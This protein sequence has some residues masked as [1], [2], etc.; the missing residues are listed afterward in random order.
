MSDAASTPAPTTEPSRAGRLLDLVR[1]LI[2]YGKELAATIRQRAVTDP[3]F[4]K[5]YFGTTDVGADPRLHLPRPASRE[6]ARS[7][8]APGRCPAGRGTA[9][10]RARSA[11]KAPAARP[12]DA[13]DPRLAR[14]PTPAQI[15]AE[16]RRR[17]ISAVLADICR[18]LGIMPSHKL[19]RDVQLLIIEHGGSLAGLVSD[20]ISRAF[21]PAGPPS[22]GVPAALRGPTLRFEA[23]AGTGPPDAVA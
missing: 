21:R 16:V 10:D 12:A 6:R 18:D 22:P 14:L 8:S 23:P 13:A 4:A 2:D 5:T 20:L 9:A 17:P 3:F 7:E 11:A 19:W 1:K 15:A